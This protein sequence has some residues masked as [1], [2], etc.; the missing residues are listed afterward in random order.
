[1]RF[2]TERK[3]APRIDI[4]SLVDVVFLLIIFFAISTTFVSTSGVTVRPPASSTASA[5]RGG[6]EVLVGQ[7]G[8]V[9][10][11]GEEIP[12]EEIRQ[13]LPVLVSEAMA[14]Q[15]AGSRVV[16][17]GDEGVEYGVLYRVL[18]AVREAG[19]EAFVLAARPS[20]DE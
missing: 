6:L 11:E 13:R 8:T 3:E 1:V 4:S 9:V 12:G 15:G 20:R 2:V 16:V 14:G 19:V 10:F 5:A 18:D 17:R 7:D